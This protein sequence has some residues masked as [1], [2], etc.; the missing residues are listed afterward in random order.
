MHTT[1]FALSQLVAR[2]RLPA[3][4]VKGSRVYEIHAYPRFWS[5]SSLMVYYV[6]APNMGV[7]K[8]RVHDY[9]IRLEGRPVTIVAISRYTLP[10]ACT[11]TL[12]AGAL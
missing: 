9:A 7:A 2:D 6:N 1:D 11:I 12:P 3:E 5:R 10:G 4:P 8:A